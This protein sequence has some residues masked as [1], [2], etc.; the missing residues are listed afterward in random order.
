MSIKIFRY[1]I[2]ITGKPVSIAMHGPILTGQ[3]EY[4]PGMDAV[5]PHVI[6]WGLHDDDAQE[7]TRTFLVIGTGWVI[8]EG[9]RYVGTAPRGADELVWHLLEIVDHPDLD[10]AYLADVA[11]QGMPEIALPTETIS[12]IETTEIKIYHD[13]TERIADAVAINGSWVNNADHDELLKLSDRFLQLCVDHKTLH[14]K[15]R[16]KRYNDGV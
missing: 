15:E 14:D 16:E 5:E 4:W 12:E 11:G 1:E 3:L 2:P 10:S 7:A 9:A 8:P 6:F 13:P